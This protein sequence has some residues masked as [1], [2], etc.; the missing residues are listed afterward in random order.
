MMGF[1]QKLGQ[2]VIGMLSG[3]D[4]V[5]FRGTR[6]QWCTVGGMSS[7]MRWAKVLY[8]DFMSFFTDKTR[9]L[10]EATEEL[11]QRH[12]DRVHYLD[13]SAHSKEDLARKMAKDKGIT[14]GLIGIFSCKETCRSFKTSRDAQSRKLR[15][16]YL[17]V[18]CLHYY[19]YYLH[20]ELGFCHVRLQT[21]VPF[22]IHICI[23]GREWLASQ[24]DRAGLG[25]LRRDNCF[26][27]L[28]DV[29]RSQELMSQ[30]LRTD[31][32]ALL[33][34]LAA[35][36]NPIDHEFFGSHPVP[37]YWS[38]DETEWASDV[39]FK[40]RGDLQQLY[41]RLIPQAMITF[42]SRDVLRFLGGRLTAGGNISGHFVGDIE[43]DLKDR[44]EGVRIKHKVNSNSVKMYDKQGSV[45][46]VE[47]T[48]N[49]PRDLR[50]FRRP[51]GRPKAKRRWLKMRK[52]VADLHRR[53][54]VSQACN[55]RYLEAL[56]ELPQDRTV[57]QI[58]QPLTMPVQYRGRRVRGLRPLEHADSRL[59]AT[60]SRAEF[61]LSGFRNRD[62]REAVY[63]K[64]P[65]DAKTLRS[66]S[67]AISRQLRMLRAH[68]LIR[69]VSSS[70]QYRLTDKGRT[71]TQVLLLTQET[72][73]SKLAA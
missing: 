20:P 66:R 5:R 43:S 22:N 56:A 37:Y 61:L 25:Y 54:E 33:D 6:R 41:R 9:R 3:F 60:I 67:A 4:R 18:R 50:T 38:A 17:P 15:L 11:A 59:L 44:P 40:S 39:M 49:Q 32:P 27:D 12:G 29:A 63:G 16:N 64:D 55:E 8:K 19:H 45:L 7:Y 34:S 58:L 26:A 47:T 57:Q 65:K 35:L 72:Q 1:I 30:Q 68:G 46:R 53:A 31:W 14:E 28:Q 48:I 23:N 52:G 69:K 10:R 73:A 62:L 51:E 2:R 42:S 13:D 21:W 70:H 24:M 36:A 71:I